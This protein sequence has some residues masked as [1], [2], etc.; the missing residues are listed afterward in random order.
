MTKDLVSLAGRR[1]LIT[2]AASG[3]GKAIALRFADAGADLI[4]LDIDAE[5]VAQ[6]AHEVSAL[7]GSVLTHTVDV[8]DKAQVDA[9]WQRFGSGPGVPDTLINNTGAYPTRD[10]LEVDTDALERSLRV[11][12]ESTLWMCQAFIAARGK[13][14]GIIVNISSIEALIPFRDDLIPYSV[15]KAGILALTRALAHTYGKR[16]F[17]AN[18]LVPGAIHTPATQRLRETT[19]RHLDIDLMKTGFH[20]DARMAMGRWGDAD[21]VARAALFLASDLASYVQGSILPVDG[22]FVPS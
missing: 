16:G 3:I 14:G 8:S 10:T 2:G 1:V 11:N 21:E 18:A 7:A 20:F 12:L 22:G 4:L 15:G 6:T 13:Q 19:L 5:G 17:R 9:F